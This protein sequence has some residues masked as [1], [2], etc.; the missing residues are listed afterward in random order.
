MTPRLWAKYAWLAHLISV[1]F[2][3]GVAY[4]GV[5]SQSTRIDKLEET[6]K[7][8]PASLARIEQAVNDMH[9]LVFKNQP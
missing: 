7:D 1:V 4:A 3:A 9:N 6:T 8:M 5:A 2:L